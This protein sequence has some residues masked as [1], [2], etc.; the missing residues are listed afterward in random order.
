MILAG[1]YTV[2]NG[3]DWSTGVRNVLHWTIRKLL[4]HTLCWTGSALP[5]LYGKWCSAGTFLFRYP[6]LLVICFQKEK[7]KRLHQT[8][9]PK[10]AQEAL[11]L[12]NYGMVFMVSFPLEAFLFY[13]K[14]YF[15]C[16]TVFTCYYFPPSSFIFVSYRLHFK[17]W[18]DRT[19]ALFLYVI[20]LFHILVVTAVTLLQ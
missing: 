6:G 5:I 17:F 4:L 10:Y 8:L 7:K 2:L 15:T 9:V 19:I 13:I 16:R 3:F 1:S 18:H 14:N 12:Q 11:W 20:V